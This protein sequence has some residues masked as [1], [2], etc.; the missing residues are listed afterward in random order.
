MD[1]RSA[2]L[3]ELPA[4]RERLAGMTSFAGGRALALALSPSPDPETVAARCAETEEA[5]L[6]RDRGLSGPG[7]ASD[8]REDV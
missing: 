7:G 8:V 5:L 6:L 1:P 2:E 3:L 4:V